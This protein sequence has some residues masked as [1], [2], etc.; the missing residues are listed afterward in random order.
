MNLFILNFGGI[1]DISSGHRPLWKSHLHA[2][3]GAVLHWSFP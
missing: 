3:G 1:T 2:Q